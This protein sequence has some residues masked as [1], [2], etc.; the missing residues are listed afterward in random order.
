MKT[1]VLEPGYKI[2][3]IL[4]EPQIREPAAIQ[5]DGLG[6]MYVLELRSYMQDIDA[7]GELLSTT[8]ISRWE[9]EDNDGISETGVV[10]LDS[11]VFPRF[12]VPFG[13]NTI[14]SME[15]NEDHLYKCTDTDN[16]GNADKKELFTACLG[17]SGNVEHHTDF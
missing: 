9:D 8:H 16:D 5:F 14:L 10:F 3:P 11:L 4:S 1:F 15:S 17:R 12:V 13:P 2:E 6:R 7:N